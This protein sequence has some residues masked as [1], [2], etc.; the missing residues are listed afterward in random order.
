MAYEIINSSPGDVVVVIIPKT[1]PAG[2]EIPLKSFSASRSVDVESLWGIGSHEKYGQLQGKM[3][4]EGDFTVGTWWVSQSQNPETWNALLQ[5][6]LALPG[7]EGLGIEFNIEVHSGG[8]GGNL[9]EKAWS[10]QKNP[11]LS[12]T[13]IP[14]GTIE[15]YERCILKGD[16]L[17][18]G[19]PG[20]LITK[21]Y[22]FTCFRRTFGSSS[23]PTSATSPDA[24]Y[25]ANTGE[26]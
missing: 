22:S 13:N 9:R 26:T 1:F 5:E 8:A 16:G 24:I 7:A 19:E 14:S 6:F 15:V 4:Y 12:H 11:A 25:A 21:K 2:L 17:D 3:D 10:G 23:A 20:S 18:I